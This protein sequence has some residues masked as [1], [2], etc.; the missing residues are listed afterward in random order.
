MKFFHDDTVNSSVK[1]RIDAGSLQCRLGVLAGGD[2]RNLGSVL[3]KF[4]HERHRAV[5]DGDAF[6]LHYLKDQFVLSIP[7]P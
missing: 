2:D 3:A 5:V 6:R 1:Q 7:N 4:R